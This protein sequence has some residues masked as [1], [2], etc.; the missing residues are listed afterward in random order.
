MTVG[1][2]DM[3]P[4]FQRREHH[5]QIGCP[6]A[7]VFVIVSNSPPGLRRDWHARFSNQLLRSLID[8][9][10]GEFRAARPLINLQDVFHGG[11]ERG[12]RVGWY[13]PLFLQMR[14][15]DVFLAHARWCY[16]LR[17][18]RCSVRRPFLPTFAK[19]TVSA[20]PGPWNKPA[21]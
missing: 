4:T 16:R 10:H 20:R 11:H 9:D 8:A 17:A 14:F 1:D 13:N 5:E 2:L 12:V 15:K 21:R 6:I 3:P 19:S 18:L 7:P